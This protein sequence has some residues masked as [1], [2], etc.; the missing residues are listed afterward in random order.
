[1]AHAV[2]VGAAVCGRHEPGGFQQDSPH[3]CSYLSRDGVWKEI[4]GSALCY[5][6]VPPLWLGN[7]DGAFKN[8]CVLTRRGSTLLILKHTAFVHVGGGCVF[9]VS[10]ACHP[11][12]KARWGPYAKGAA[13]W[14]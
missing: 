7:S 2:N 5:L 6:G 10:W 11:L 3:P 1:M 13:E 9:E 14:P 4:A 8:L 12:D